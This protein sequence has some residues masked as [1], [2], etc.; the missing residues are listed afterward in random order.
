VEK[1]IA[2]FFNHIPV[3]EG[4]KNATSIKALSQELSL[5]IWRSMGEHST[6][7]RLIDKIKEVAALSILSLNKDFLEE[8]RL[9]ED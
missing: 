1:D 9:E 5:L 6:K 2:D 3:C 7:N 4:N 8:R